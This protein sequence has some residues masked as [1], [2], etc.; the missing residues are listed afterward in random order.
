[1]APQDPVDPERRA[2]LLRTPH[3]GGE[4][5][6][7]DIALTATVEKLPRFFSVGVQIQGAPDR[8]DRSVAVR[9]GLS[10]QIDN[11]GYDEENDRYHDD[12]GKATIHDVHVDD[13]YSPSARKRL[14]EGFAR[15]AVERG[16]TSIDQ[17]AFSE[18]D[19]ETFREIFGDD[20][21]SFSEV[22][23]EN[24]IVVDESGE[25]IPAGRYELSP[26]EVRKKLEALRIADEKARECEEKYGPDV[27]EWPQEV[28][29]ERYA[30]AV[31]H[32]ISGRH[33]E[34]H[35][36]TKDLDVSGWEPDMP[37]GKKER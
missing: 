9:N 13:E 12:E 22:V 7:A 31:K 19:L 30:F 4:A 23:Y 20:R 27:E 2:G 35:A 21:L 11:R 14:Y 3:E 18:E 34:V 15:I 1:M 36:D 32:Q 29:E 17:P 10:G 26:E 6:E 16:A 25:R 8:H 28:H 37:V 5:Q 24:L 33:L